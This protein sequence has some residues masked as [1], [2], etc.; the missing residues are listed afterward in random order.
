MQYT[1]DIEEAAKKCATGEKIVFVITNENKYT[2]LKFS[3]Y[4]LKY[5]TLREFNHISYQKEK[6][7]FYYF[8]LC[9]AKLSFGKYKL[10]YDE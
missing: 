3:Y 6:D 1:K 4:Q 10:T 8:L 9:C 2:L 5:K 7:L